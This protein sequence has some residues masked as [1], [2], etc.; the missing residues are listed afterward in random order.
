MTR[1]FINFFIEESQ[2][3]HFVQLYLLLG[4][5]DGKGNY[6]LLPCTMVMELFPSSLKLITLLTNIFWSL[7]HLVGNVR[8]FDN[9]F[10]MLD[11]PSLS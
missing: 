10:C 1:T 2:I 6:S 7:I 4:L 3:L 11:S 8:G 9:T 5:L